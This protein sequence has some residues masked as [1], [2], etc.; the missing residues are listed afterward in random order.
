MKIASL[1]T[2]FF[3]LFTTQVECKEYESS[4]GFTIDLPDKWLAITKKQIETLSGADVFDFNNKTFA[5]MDKNVLQQTIALVKQG[6]IEAFLNTESKSPIIVDNINVFEGNG[7]IPQ[8]DSELSRQC[9]LLP[10]QLSNSYRKNTNVYE[11]KFITIN[12][13]N[14]FMFE[15]DAPRPGVRN[16]NY[17]FQ[18]T[19]NTQVLLSIG[20]P[21]ENRS[22]FKQEIQKIISSI[23][24]QG[25]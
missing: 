1:I 16:L 12:N 22:S 19:P 25:R 10:R 17:S 15:A 11:C 7:K 2:I 21:E 8:D 24:I 14:F 4:F 9:E 13:V 18:K 20:F 23:K 5:S 6:R 3:I